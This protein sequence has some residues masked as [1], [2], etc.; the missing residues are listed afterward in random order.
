MKL[1]VPGLPQIVQKAFDTLLNRG[2]GRDNLSNDVLAGMIVESG[3]NANGE[4]VRWGNGLQICWGSVDIGPINIEYGSNGTLYRSVPGIWNY[5]SLFSANPSVS[6]IVMRKDSSG[7]AA[8]ISGDSVMNTTRFLFYGT[9]S[10]SSDYDYIAYLL[11][12]GRWK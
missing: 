3:S 1:H 4:Y 2:I 5:P 6:G 11:A 12:I 9:R 8:Y 10:S 7:L